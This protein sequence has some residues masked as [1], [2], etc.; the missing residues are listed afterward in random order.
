MIVEQQLD[1]EGWETIEHSDQ[2]VSI[3]ERS[4]VSQIRFGTKFLSTKFDF[5]YGNFINISLHKEKEKPSS[6]CI[7]KGCKNSSNSGKMIGNLCVPC[8]EFI[9]KEEGTHSQA[10][11]NSLNTRLGEIPK[12]DKNKLY[13][14]LYGEKET[15]TEL[16]I[17]SIWK[18]IVETMWG[19]K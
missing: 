2:I 16:E 4:L 7:V 11:R 3:P 1:E 14:F 19:T 8:Y 15:L 13:S 18:K 9:T 10:Y 12:I 5:D 17:V 6:N